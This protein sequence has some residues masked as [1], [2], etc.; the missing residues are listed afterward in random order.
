MNYK[1]NI[2]YVGS[3]FSGW[4][5]QKQKRT[6]QGEIEN[7]LKKIFKNQKINLIGSGRTD[8]GVHAYG[9]VANVSLETQMSDKE[10]INALNGNLKDDIYISNCI[11]VDEEF[12]SR[13][14]AIK[15]E[16]VY[17]IMNNNTKVDNKLYN[18]LK[19]K[20]PNLKLTNED[21]FKIYNTLLEKK[22]KNPIEKTIQ[23]III[24]T[25]NIHLQNKKTQHNII[26][27]DILENLYNYNKQPSIQEAELNINPID[28]PS[29]EQN[30]FKLSSP[31][32][33]FYQ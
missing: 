13:F 32:S 25:K 14:S 29:M 10:L 8:S 12:N 11:G 24:K 22:I 2:S 3:E 20:I 4:Q 5:I 23:L 7:A 1:L 27:N 19:T 18:I 28:K 21:I 15:R 33:S 17:K 9:Q 6:I 31:P 26:E 16:Y 30:N